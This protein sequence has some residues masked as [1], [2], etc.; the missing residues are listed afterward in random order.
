MTKRM[1]D[2]GGDNPFATGSTE[3]DAADKTCL[4][5]VF[6]KHVFHFLVK[7]ILFLVSIFPHLFQLFSINLYL[8]Y[9]NFQILSSKH[10]ISRSFSQCLFLKSCAANIAFF[11]VFDRLPLLPVQRLS[12]SFPCILFKVFLLKNVKLCKIITYFWFFNLVTLIILMFYLNLPFTLLDCYWFLYS[13][14]LLRS[15]SG[16]RSLSRPKSYFGS[17][18][19]SGFNSSDYNCWES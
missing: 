17:V 6:F 13:A 9:F 8:K 1:A 4:L 11:P 3:K 15:F 19:L 14:V 16:W 12:V 7:I 5:F 10:D 18:G 2:F